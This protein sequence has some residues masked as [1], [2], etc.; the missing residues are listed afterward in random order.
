MNTARLQRIREEEKQYHEDCFEQHRLYNKGSWLDK[1]IPLIM[2][3]VKL[4][5]HKHPL[6]ILDLGCGVGRNSIPLAQWL[7]SSLG[8][9]HGVDL[10]DM[11]LEKLHTYSKEFRVEHLI[12]TEQADISTYEIPPNSYDYII[13]ASSL[14]HVKSDTA[15]KQVLR[16][17]AE[18]TK[19][20]GINFI[21]MNTNI[22][23]FNRQ[24]GRKRETLIEVV[25]PKENALAIL[26]AN[27]EGWEQLHLSDTPMRLDITRHDVP[28]ILQADSLTYVVKKPS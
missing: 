21:L 1:P 19:P 2:E 13:A 9:V 6:S 23:E 17:M 3:L 22:E 25:M 15:F 18:G 27:Y 11:A 10:L 8:H 16:R 26:Q 12:S 4:I 7:K 28:V 14:E 5:D 24:T 20:G